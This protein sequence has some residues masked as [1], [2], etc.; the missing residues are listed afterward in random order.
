MVKIVV[1]KVVLSYCVMYVWRAIYIDGF[2]IYILTNLQSDALQKI[3]HLKRLFPPRNEGAVIRRDMLK[4][5]IPWQW[6]HRGHH[7]VLTWWHDTHEE[8]GS[9]LVHHFEICSR[10]VE[11]QPS[12][13]WLAY[14][15]ICPVKCC[16]VTRC[17]NLFK[18]FPPTICCTKSSWFNSMAWRG[19]KKIC[20]CDFFFVVHA[21]KFVP[22]TCPFVL[23]NLK[24]RDIWFEW[25]AG[26]GVVLG[27]LLEY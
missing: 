19:D 20:L 13:F 1:L 3:Y 26:S 9:N 2:D 18:F 8:N 23:A 10:I 25:D 5:Q 24:D 16:M 22:A 12:V 6:S 14:S 11:N 4:R 21:M 15:N 27:L 17:D 7:V